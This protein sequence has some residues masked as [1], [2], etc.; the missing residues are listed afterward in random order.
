MTL[1]GWMDIQGYS[2]EVEKG[3]QYEKC[4]TM[5]YVKNS[6]KYTRQFQTEKPGSH[7]MLLRIECENKVICLASIYRT[8]KLTGHG[9]HL[10]A[11]S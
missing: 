11:F 8:Y 4:R 1:H 6:V 2:V 3:I 5:L 10:K 7:I 9:S